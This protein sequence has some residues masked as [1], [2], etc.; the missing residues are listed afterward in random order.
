MTSEQEPI[1]EP[2]NLEDLEVLSPR[3]PRVFFFR[4]AERTYE[5]LSEW[6]EEFSRLMGIQGKAL[7]EECPRLH[8][9]EIFSDFKKR[10][11]EQMVLLHFNGNAR[12]PRFER[13]AFFPGHW[14]Y[15]NPA[16]VMD[17][18]PAEDGLADIPVSDTS[19]F[20][21]AA[22]T[23]QKLHDDVGLCE[24][25]ED[26]SLN[27]HRSEQV[28]LIAV[29]HEA[30]TIRVRR[31]CY[32]TEPRAFRAGEAAAAAHVG[33][34]PW[35]EDGNLMWFY[36]YSTRCPRDADGKRCAEVL[37]DQIAGWF[38][39]G[40]RLD[41]FDGLE[42]DVQMHSLT[43]HVYGYQFDCRWPDADGDGRPDNGVFDGVDTY[44]VGVIEFCRLLRSMMGEGRFIM[45]DGGEVCQRAFGI[46]NG[47]ESEGWPS[48]QDPTIEDWS[49]GINR[50]MFWRDN[51]RQPALNYMKFHWR[52]NGDQTTAG[53]RRLFMAVAALTDSAIAYAMKPPSEPDRP[54]PALWDEMVKGTEGELGWLGRALGPPVRLARRTEPALVADDPE[55]LAE[56]LENEGQGE[57]LTAPEDGAL[58]IRPSEPTGTG[59]RFRLGE[60]PNPGP[61]LLCLVTLR[62]RH[63]R[64][65][66]PESARLVHAAIPRPATRL[67]YMNRFLS[68]MNERD[69]TSEFYFQTIPDEPVQLSFEIEGVEPVW[70]SRLEVYD[71]SDA[72]CR[73]FEN[74]VVLANPSPRPYA[75]DLEELFPGVD[76]RRL[77]GRSSQYP[78]TNDGSPVDGAVELG[79][80]DALFLVKE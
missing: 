26:G 71:H 44:A 65:Y 41:A 33:E 27:W 51:A 18:V 45:A 47:I 11:P 10:H 69:F 76:L 6:D 79:G 80:K 13:D 9:V 17:D 8:N 35:G 54:Y 74:G 23:F 16:T 19:L 59:M 32:G 3:Y 28:Q 39:P 66:P 52:K 30:G 68:W 61:E 2:S 78:E 25:N 22:G 40:G 57:L 1:C 29:D 7:Y 72:M 31:G 60:L 43:N 20:C 21:T 24:L 14:V 73:E 75:F 67:G 34:G 48:G 77:R 53:V 58:R 37:A 46:L 64:G 49:G 12:D 15:Y 55:G 70:L 36:N 38:A 56:L 4:S 63:M 5:P 50:H 62:G 42:F